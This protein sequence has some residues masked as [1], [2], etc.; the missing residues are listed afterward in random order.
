[1]PQYVYGKNV[2]KQYLLDKSNLQKI[3]LSGN[4]KEI[5]D[6]ASQNG[7]SIQEVDRRKLMALVGD[8]KHQGVVAVVDDYPEYTLEEVLESIPSDEVPLLVLLDGIEDPHNLGAILRSVDAVGAHG[9]ILKKDRAVGLTP[10]VAKVSAGAIDTVKCATVVNLS[11][12]IDELKE[13]G[14]WIVGTDMNGQDA[15]GLNYDFPC[16]LVIG[17]EGKG[18]SRLVRE[19]C[20]YI[21]S[22]PMKGKISSLNASVSTGVLLYTIYNKR[23][24]L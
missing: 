16:V 12:A 14:Y 17:N 8:V 22:I 3:Y 10:T 1:M 13:K 19:K 5:K 9:V 15:W 23:F 7:I 24:P 11:R 20:D 21:V 2:V 6:L 4:D 18:M